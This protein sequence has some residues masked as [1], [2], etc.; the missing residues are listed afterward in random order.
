MVSRKSKCKYGRKMEVFTIQAFV[1]IYSRKYVD[2]K[3]NRK[4]GKPY[5]SFAG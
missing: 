1:Q 5:E 2:T 4:H 3:G